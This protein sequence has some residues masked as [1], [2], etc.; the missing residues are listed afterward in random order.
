MASS[1]THIKNVKN[2]LHNIIII[3]IQQLL[4][5]RGQYSTNFHKVFVTI[6]IEDLITKCLT[7]HLQC[8]NIYQ[9]QDKPTNS[10]YYLYNDCDFT[11]YMAIVFTH[12][13]IFNTILCII[14]NIKINS[15]KNH[16]QPCFI[17]IIYVHKT[18]ILHINF[19]I[20]ISHTIFLI[21]QQLPLFSSI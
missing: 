1:Y 19:I 10:M 13:T 14:I 16:Y 12:I 20:C 4:P 9:K 3:R 7:I 5:D 17:C 21:K 11:L 6:N 18:D 15:Y 8:Y 2:N